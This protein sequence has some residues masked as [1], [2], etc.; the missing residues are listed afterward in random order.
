MESGLKKINDTQI[1]KRSY[2]LFIFSSFLVGIISIVLGVYF[3]QHPYIS[4]SKT[5]F[6]Q[7]PH[8]EDDN[9]LEALQAFKK[10]CTEITKRTPTT[11]IKLLPTNKLED[12]QT[13]C[14]AASA[15]IYPDNQTARKFFE[16]WFQPYSVKSNFS[17]KGL[18][19]GYYLPLLHASLKKDKNYSIPVYGLP[20]DLIKLNLSAF[21]PNYENK[22]ITGQLTKNNI[23]RPY[24]DRAKING[25]AIQTN[26]PVLVWS[27]NLIDVF[28]AQIQGSA[29]V[30]LP[31]KQRLLLGYAGANGRAYT[32]IGKILIANHAI[33]KTEIS[34]QTIRSWLEQH[35]DQANTILNSNASYVFFK[36]LNG[37]D[38]IGS[39]TV[40]LTTKRSLAVDRNYIPLGTPVWLDTVT[41][42]N[43]TS[44]TLNKFKH[45]L[46]AQDTGG[47]I[48]G[49]I[50]GDVY[51]GAGEEAGF[52]AGHMQSPGRYWILLPRKTR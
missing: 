52:I 32:P 21:N 8:W 25:G 3:H 13:I 47:A 12:W 31:N 42:N 33:K 43:Q 39:E 49:A 17:A 37:E 11:G 5:T 2:R 46:I 19:T 27:N 41:P 24:P 30:E 28:F 50:R 45:L 20:N 48:K 35:P 9:Q 22:S 29:I 16:Y 36:L 23:F 34:M 1:N 38:P 51:W 14:S 10:S 6:N 40:P 26:A 15:L 7:L 4:Y 18:F 44:N